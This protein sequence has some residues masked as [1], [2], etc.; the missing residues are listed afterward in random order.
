AFGETAFDLG[1]ESQPPSRPV[2]GADEG[3]VDADLG[4]G[5]DRCELQGLGGD[6]TAV[7]ADELGKDGEHEGVGLRVQDVGERAS[8]EGSRSGGWDRALRRAECGA[9]P[10]DRDADPG[11]V[12]RADD[13]Q[14]GE[15]RGKELQHD[16]DPEA[17]DRHVKKAARDDSAD[18]GKARRPSSDQCAP[19]DERH[20][21]AGEDDDPE[22]QAEEEQKL[23]RGDHRGDGPFSSRVKS[24]IQFVSQVLPPSAEKACSQRGLWLA[25]RDQMKRTTIGL[26]SKTSGPS[27][28]PWSPWNAPTTGGWSAP[29]RLSAQ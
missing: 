16:R 11:L 2:R 17:S 28:M 20:V 9:A 24:M 21:Q 10:P 25:M 4:S 13:E 27:K 3:S 22:H 5:D 14:R 26:P 6:G 1:M 18:R 23:G 8:A 19:E 29:V 15:R 7:G 12:G